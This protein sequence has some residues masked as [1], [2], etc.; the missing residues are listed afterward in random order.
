MN[1]PG[2]PQSVL[3]GHI[4]GSLLLHQLKGLYQSLEAQDLAQLEQVYTADVEF[5]DPAHTLHGCLALRRYL[6]KLVG[7]VTLYRMRYIDEVIGYNAAYL[8]WEMDYAHPRLAGGNTI[9]VRGMS[10]LKFTDKVFYHE[11]SYDLGAMLY[12]HIP[13]L[14]MPVR[15]IKQRI[16]G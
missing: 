15:K 13:L 14:G 10:H 5:R 2:E 12:E 9:T 7:N 11:D 4:A 3:A 1:K 16:G 8:T 6:R